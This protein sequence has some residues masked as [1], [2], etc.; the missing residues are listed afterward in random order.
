VVRL[1]KSRGQAPVL[2]VVIMIVMVVFT[3]YAMT[4]YA[5]V[6]QSPNSSQSNSISEISDSVNFTTSSNLPVVHNDSCTASV[7]CANI[8]PIE[9]SEISQSAGIQPN[10]VQSLPVETST[11]AQAMINCPVVAQGNLI[12]TALDSSTGAPLAGLGVQATETTPSCLQGVATVDLG[13]SYTNSSGMASLCCKSG[14]YKLLVEYGQTAY[15]ASANVNPGG[16][17]C[18]SMFIPSGR[19][20]ITYSATLRS[21]CT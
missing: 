16:V 10:G 15:S 3:I 11:S 8:A 6:I 14:A 4:E 9:S 20:N 18:V 7:S 21:D 12:L 13:Q 5:V 1:I 17:T 19:V 2:T